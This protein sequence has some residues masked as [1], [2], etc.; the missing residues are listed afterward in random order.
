MN[1]VNELERFVR[2][3]GLKMGMFDYVNFKMPC[4]NCGAG[5]DGWQT[6]DSTCSLELVEPDGLMR[7]YASCPE[8]DAW[9]E[10]SR[11]TPQHYPDR[12]EPL[13]RTEVEAQGFELSVEPAP[14]A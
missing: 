9:L 8:C 14:N 11:P 4:P 3:G 12:R 1:E 13:T 5:V 7:F 2:C 6:K 10:F